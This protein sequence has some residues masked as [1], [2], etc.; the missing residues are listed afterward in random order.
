MSPSMGRTKTKNISSQ[1]SLL[2]QSPVT[3]LAHAS[4]P[5]VLAALTTAALPSC[6]HK[7]EVVAVGA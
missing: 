3:T 4:K 7:A 1:S 5:L 2:V 6:L